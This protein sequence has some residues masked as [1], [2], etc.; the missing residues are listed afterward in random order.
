MTTGLGGEI[1]LGVRGEKISFGFVDQRGV[2][3]NVV[4]FVLVEI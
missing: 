3:G 2:A 4:K 1:L